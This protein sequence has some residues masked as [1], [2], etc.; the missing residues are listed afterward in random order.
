MIV[1]DKKYK[2]NK[3]YLQVTEALDCSQF[4]LVGNKLKV[5]VVEEERCVCCQVECKKFLD[6]TT[7]GPES[8]LA[9]C[10]SFLLLRLL[11]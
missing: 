3:F 6:W 1:D 2:A 5:E 10:S 11:Q 7:C 9:R 8:A 4:N